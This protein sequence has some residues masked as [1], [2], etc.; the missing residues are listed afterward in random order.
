MKSIL[1]T[2]LILLSC[3][4]KSQQNKF[5]IIDDNGI[6]EL[7]IGMTQEE[8][9][10]FLHTK[11]TLRNA[12]TKAISHI[13]TAYVTYKN[14]KIEVSFERYYTTDTNFYMQ[15]NRLTTSSP[16]CKTVNGVGVG[17]DKLAV[18]NKYESQRI[19]IYPEFEEG[20]FNKM[21]KNKS[22]INVYYYES[23]RYLSFTLVNK[24]VI[25]V[26]VGRYYSDA[27]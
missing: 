7:K 1:I 25:N 13:D 16:L 19:T 21:S 6:G 22:G 20:D 18:V 15:V 26:S 27:E 3:T 4:A 12:L 9:E 8:L 14:M 17:A 11:F 23:E 5:H 10:K 2:L 24:K